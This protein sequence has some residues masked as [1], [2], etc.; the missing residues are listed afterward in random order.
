MQFQDSHAA[1]ILAA[2]KGHIDIIKY[3]I[4]SNAYADMQF[5]D[6][7]SALILAAQNGHSDIMKYLIEANANVNS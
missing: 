1:L 5:E 2:Q 7:H 4:E 3:L 6:G